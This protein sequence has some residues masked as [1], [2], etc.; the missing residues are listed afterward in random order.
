MSDAPAASG[1]AVSTGF[2]LP[3]AARLTEQHG[4]S[5]TLTSAPGQG[6]VV[7]LSFPAA[8]G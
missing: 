7:R 3:I 2:G 1:T 8:R 4:G 5:L 6:T